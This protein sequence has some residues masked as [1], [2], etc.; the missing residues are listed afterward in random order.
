MKRTLSN[1]ILSTLALTFLSIQTKIK[2]AKCLNIVLAGG[3]GKVGRKLSSSLSPSEHSITILARNAFLASAPSRV[4]SDFGW[5]GKAFLDA[6]P[7]VSLRDWDG[8][9]LLDIVGC[10]W[11]GWQEDT[12]PKADVIVNLVGG[13]TEQRVMATER[14]VRASLEYNTDVFQICVSP[15]EEDMKL[16][17]PGALSDKLRRVKLCEDMV[18]QN[19]IN[20][21]CL[22]VEM[23][24]SDNICT[25]IIESIESK[26]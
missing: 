5:L 26:S 18:E 6:H 9:D 12:I 19:C 21:A 13:Y 7:H 10:D 3:T 23:N 1:R 25:K 2:P 17:S 15:T 22:R 20:H 8:G 11:M 4:S 16:Y 24:D 14:L